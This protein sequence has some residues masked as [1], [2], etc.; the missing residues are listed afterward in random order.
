M[1]CNFDFEIEE[2]REV[3]VMGDDES[4]DGDAFFETLYT[5]KPDGAGQI[6]CNDKP[7]Y[8]GYPEGKGEIMAYRIVETGNKTEK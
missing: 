5:G 6:V 7:A 1:N 3:R 8:A 2:I 4:G